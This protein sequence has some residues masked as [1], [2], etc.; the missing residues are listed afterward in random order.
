MV[1]KSIVMEI[2]NSIFLNIH[3]YNVDLFLCGGASTK[4][5]ITKRD[6]IRSFLE[7]HK[8]ISIF[9][10]EDMFMELLN[11]KKYDLFT[12]EQ[13]LT[14]NSDLIIIVCESPGSFTEL[15]AFVSNKNLL[16][17]LVVLVQTKYKNAKSFIMQGPV[18]FIQAYNKQN[19]VFYNKDIVE[20]EKQIKKITARFYRKNK[21]IS[22]NIDLISGQ[23]Y[24]I[25]LLLFFYNKIESNELVEIVRAI[26]IDNRF[27]EERFDM[28]Y[29][30]AIRR[31]YKEG[32][33]LKSL[34]D[35]VYYNCLTP[36]GYKY[37]KHLLEEVSMDNKYKSINSIRLK[38]MSLQ[39]C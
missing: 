5:H 30:S 8:N 29:K 37:A 21:G 9:Y 36:K 34:E 22:K 1:D 25:I 3:H 10:P 38:I 4:D 17:K 16:N 15:G 20:L 14:E 12:L 2:Y 18:R 28:L 11:R 6:E 39:Y 7:T 33:L 27:A 24:F 32:L 31:M 19:I 13:F 23:L 26:Y 35:G